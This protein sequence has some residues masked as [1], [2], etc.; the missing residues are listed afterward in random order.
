[1]IY[2]APFKM[3]KTDSAITNV[4]GKAKYF[5]LY[6][7][8]T[9]ETKVIENVNQG[10]PLILEELKVLGVETILTPHLGPRPL[11][12]THQLGMRVFYSGADRILLEPAVEAFKA[13]NFPEITE[14]N[15]EQ[16]HSH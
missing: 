2:A 14:H 10:G 6:N 4:F 7:D 5:G 11:Q 8:E 15:I 9:K 1:M 13:G 3:N 16:Y 12:I